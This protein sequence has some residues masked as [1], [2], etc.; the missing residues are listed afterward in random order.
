METICTS[1]EFTG[2]RDPYTGAPLTVKLY[3]LP[4]GAVRFRVEGGYDV[5]APCPTM[6][7]A[8]AAWSMKDGVSGMRDPAKG[9]FV[10]AYTGAAMEPRKVP[11]GYAFSGGFS[12]ELFHTRDEVLAAFAHLDGRPAPAP[13]VRIEAV[14]DP[15]PPPRYHGHDLSDDTMS[16]AESLVESA[17]SKLGV[18]PSSPVSMSKRKGRK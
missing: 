6:E 9:G 2:R 15:P 8:V 12:P 1:D 10:C 17:K 13:S 16:R 14:P 7:A 5:T 18:A 11:G 4:G 3:V